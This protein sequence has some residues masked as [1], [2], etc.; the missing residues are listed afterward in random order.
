M[1]PVEAEFE[2]G[3][4]DHDLQERRAREQA[5]RHGRGKPMRELAW[6]D[7]Y[8]RNGRPVPQYEGAE[9]HDTA[10]DRCRATRAIEQ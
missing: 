9:Q 1:K 10:S 4:T 2:T 3:N 8:L 6:T 7:E 5:A